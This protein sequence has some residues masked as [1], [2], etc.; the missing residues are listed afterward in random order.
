MHTGVIWPRG[1][2]I[3]NRPLIE[4][5]MKGCQWI[6][7]DVIFT[8]FIHDMCRWRLINACNL[9]YHGLIILV[10]NE[11]NATMAACGKSIGGICPALGGVPT[12]RVH[13]R[14]CQLKGWSAGRS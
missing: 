8:N 7:R 3:G 1:V 6:V 11:R 10:G 9:Q 4:A 5:K 14:A 13:L 12:F 2:N